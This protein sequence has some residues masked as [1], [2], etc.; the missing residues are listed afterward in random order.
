M[1]IKT[2]S[3]RIL[4]NTIKTNTNKERAIFDRSKD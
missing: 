3:Y 4:H 2:K 1:L